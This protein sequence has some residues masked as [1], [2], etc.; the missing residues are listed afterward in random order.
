MSAT[1]KAPHVRQL[2]NPSGT[3]TS[4]AIDTKLTRPEQEIDRATWVL[5]NSIG[6][7]T[8]LRPLGCDIQSVLR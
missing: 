2:T 8:F 4:R 3:L 1:Q 7:R 5:V 6:A